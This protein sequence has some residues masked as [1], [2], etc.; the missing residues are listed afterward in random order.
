MIKHRCFKE[1]GRLDI[2]E[3]KDERTIGKKAVRFDTKS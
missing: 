2:N 1:F 3:Q